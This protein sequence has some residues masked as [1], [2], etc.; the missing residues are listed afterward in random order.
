MWPNPQKT[1]DLVIFTEEILN[2]NLHFLC[3][4]IEL[5]SLKDISQLTHVTS[6]FNDFT[7][8]F[9]ILSSELVV[10]TNYN[11]ALRERIIQLESKSVGNAGYH[12]HESLK[13]NPT[14]QKL[15]TRNWK[16][17]FAR[18]WSRLS[19]IKLDFSESSLV[20][21]RYPHRL[22]ILHFDWPI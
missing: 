14:I 7:R 2:G 9:E 10:S 16:Q 21:C 17:I 6:P 19:T 18:L 11:H 15:A 22:T 3:S 5:M 4:E 13:L 12:H 1:A 20:F 8:K